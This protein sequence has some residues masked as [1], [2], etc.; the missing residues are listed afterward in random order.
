MLLDRSPQSRLVEAAGAR[1][2]V[3]AFCIEVDLLM[4]GDRTARVDSSAAFCAVDGEEACLKATT[5]RSVAG[6]VALRRDCLAR[7]DECRG[8]VGDGLIGLL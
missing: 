2:G 6:L 1:V 3:S 4:M 8:F 7:D 5:R